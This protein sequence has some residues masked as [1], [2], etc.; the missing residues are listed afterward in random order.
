M[1][2]SIHAFR[3]DGAAARPLLLR[4]LDTASR[5]DVVSMGVDSAAALA[6][7][8]EHDGRARPGREPLPLPAG[9]LV[10]Q[11]GPPLR[12]LGAALG[13]RLLRPPRPARRGARLDRGA[14]E[15]RGPD[16]PPDALAALAHALGE[17]ALA[18][19]HADA[20]AEQ[21]SRAA[22][23]HA[24][25]E[26]PFERAQ[27][28]LRAGVA[29]AA[30]GRREAAVERLV[31]AHRTA[32]RL[33]AA[34]LAAQAA[35]EVARLGESVERRLGRR[36]AADH[37]HAGLSRRE[38]EVMRLVASGGTNREI[39]TALVLSTRTVDMHVRNIL[40]KLRCRSRTEAVAK[41]GDLG[42]LA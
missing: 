12:G 8:E 1:L 42:L 26:I 35:A 32:R 20:A 41:A 37:E 31:E 33:G 16:G 2:G 4:C 5:L 29:L 25:L 6:V 23:L 15:H 21:I 40:A 22:D 39:A 17:T 13:G 3:G 14:V 10:A 27:I 30:A 34:P 38:L 24:S 18:E 11:R 28:Q 9:A 36:A 7:L 19:G